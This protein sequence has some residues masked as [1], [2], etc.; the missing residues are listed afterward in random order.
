MYTSEQIKDYLHSRLPDEEMEAIK[1]A[2]HTDAELAARVRAAKDW[3]ALEQMEIRAQAAEA[4][5]YAQQTRNSHRVKHSI[6]RWGFGVTGV[7]LLVLAT[8]YVSEWLFPS[9]PAEIEQ[10]TATPSPENT[11]IDTIDVPSPP[12]ASPG[13]RPIAV[14]SSV[15][16]AEFIAS[17][18]E[19]YGAK[20]ID[21]SMWYD[22]GKPSETHRVSK[23]F[24]AED[25]Y[26]AVELY[27]LNQLDSVLALLE[28]CTAPDCNYLAGHAY[29][30]KGN[31]EK[32]I[33]KF[34]E[35]R[36]RIAFS[37]TY[38]K[39]SY[40]LRLQYYL[41][42][43]YFATENWAAFQTT[44]ELLKEEGDPY[45]FP[46]AE[47]LWKAA[48]ARKMIRLE[49]GLLLPDQMP[50]IFSLAQKT[51]AKKPLRDF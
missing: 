43:S 6:L 32:A 35:S 27:E 20:K 48:S 38:L 44:Y 17:S 1:A 36:E 33:G 37:R 16:D 47:D 28:N 31:Y 14:S 41:F 25:F 40:G 34:N 30:S 39:E 8:P 3:L 50:A 29:F 11:T 12:V 22:P 9:K 19:K 42:L 23:D 49:Q 26:Y 7:L 18:L 5:Q 2:I 45:Y 10:P 13:K 51:L 21:L 46:R 4:L 15:S 24:R